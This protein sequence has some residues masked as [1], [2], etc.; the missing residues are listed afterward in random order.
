MSP[1]DRELV[2]P[3][4]PDYSDEEAEAYKT[5]FRVC[6]DLF[7]NA[8]TTYREALDDADDDDAESDVCQEC[9]GDLLASMGADETITPEGTVCPE[10]EL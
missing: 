1:D 4:P 7:A 10:C 6:A 9:G 2:I 5:G 8:A 3:I